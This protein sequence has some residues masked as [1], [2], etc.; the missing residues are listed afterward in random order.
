MQ[1]GEGMTPEEAQALSWVGISMAVAALTVVVSIY[2]DVR[3]IR[4]LIEKEKS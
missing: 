3:A 4:L 1:K 2:L